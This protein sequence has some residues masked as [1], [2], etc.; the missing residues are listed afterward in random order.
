MNRLLT[1]NQVAE[2]LGVKPGWVWAQARAGRIPHV[3]LGRYRRFRE[4]AL[5]DW[6]RELEGPTGVDSMPTEAPTPR[7]ARRPDATA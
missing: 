1:A 7:F 6:L 4:E 2:R 5:D 3:Q